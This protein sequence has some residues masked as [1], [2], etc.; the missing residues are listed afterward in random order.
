MILY[1]AMVKGQL[2]WD[3][4]MLCKTLFWPLLNTKGQEQKGGIMNIFH[5]WSGTELVTIIFGA[6][7]QTVVVLQI[8]CCCQDDD[9]CKASTF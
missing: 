7:L 3:T 6:Y 2:H 8:L 1:I 9:V 4:L 5:I